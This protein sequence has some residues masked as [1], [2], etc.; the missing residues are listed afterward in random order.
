[1]DSKLRIARGQLLQSPQ[2]LGTTVFLILRDL[3]GDEALDWDPIT[4]A[5]EF[6]EVFRE[7]PAA[8]VLDR[9][10]AVA[11]VMTGDVFFHQVG[12]FW[13]VANTLA[14]GAPSFSVMDPVT[15]PEASWAVLEV[16]ILRDMLP[17]G[18]NVRRFLRAVLREEGY[19]EDEYPDILDLVLDAT[20]VPSDDEIL[21]AGRVDAAATNIDRVVQ[22]TSETT[23]M[24]VAQCDKA[25]LTPALQRLM[26]EHD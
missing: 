22:Y 20:E 5:M 15:V 10:S 21:S 8:P 4:L 11:V 7:E 17:F 2:T 18:T 25:G 24:L 13:N 14:S 26:G 1:M 16:A 3:W 9:L 6:K 12:A 23:D 19:D